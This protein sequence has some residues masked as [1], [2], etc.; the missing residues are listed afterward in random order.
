MTDLE[1]H[2]TNNPD[3]S[4]F[5]VYLGDEL[6]GF[7]EYRRNGDSVSFTH[8]EV[9]EQFEGKGLAGRLARAALDDA[10]TEGLAVLPNCPYIA[11]WIAKHPEYVDLV[12]ESQ[13]ARFDL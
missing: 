2:V 4:R 13:R 1:P 3:K 8:T 6:A 10:R 11:S 12:P 5:E 9:A 7:A